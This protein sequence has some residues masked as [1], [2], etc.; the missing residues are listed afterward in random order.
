MTHVRRVRVT[1]LR[2]NVLEAVH[3]HAASVFAYAATIP[4]AQGKSGKSLEE[5]E[6]GFEA[7]VAVA[8]YVG[9]HWNRHVGVERPKRPDVGANIEVKS[10]LTLQS[11]NVDPRELRRDWRY[12]LARG[13]NPDLWLEGWAW[14]ERIAEA[15]THANPGRSPRHRVPIANLL[16][17]ETLE[18]V[19]AVT[20]LDLR[21][22]SARV[23]H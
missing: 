9:Q 2:P 8:L 12:V 19:A 21:S 13:R 23:G 14:G 16:P 15:P 17:I 4:N 18:P 22:Y 10:T 5:E 20:V 7:E 11:L 1:W 3:A 6:A